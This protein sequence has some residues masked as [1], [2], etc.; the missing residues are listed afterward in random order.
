MRDYDIYVLGAFVLIVLLTR[1][2][3]RRLPEFFVA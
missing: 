2:G 1:H 3:V